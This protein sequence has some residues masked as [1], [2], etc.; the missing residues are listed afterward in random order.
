MARMTLISFV[1]LVGMGAL[2]LTGCG[3]SSGTVGSLGKPGSPGTAGPVG[4]SGSAAAATGAA[5][6]A[7]GAAPGSADRWVLS[8]PS[9]VFGFPQIQP[10][11]A[12][13]DKIKSLLAQHAA[14]LG[15]SGPQVI[16]VYDDPTHDV[17]VIFAGYN[18]SGF[19]PDKLKAVFDVLPVTTDDGA[20][21]RVTINSMMIDP[22]PHGGTA[23]CSSSLGQ[24]GQL[25]A[26]STA[27][28]WMT[29]T[30]LGVISYFPKP[31]HQKAV[32]GVGPD[33]MG[34]AMRELRDQVEH[35][36]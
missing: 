25:A 21:D 17:Y 9:S 8:A 19:V 34:K 14:Q 26:E 30:T 2:A 6:L 11:P 1:G 3:S 33:V 35:H 5:T 27:C 32:F 24:S 36:A 31:D 15:V 10:A 20:G 4:T 28:E 16:A 23:G 13:L 22:G 7:T 12:T 29:S 18:G